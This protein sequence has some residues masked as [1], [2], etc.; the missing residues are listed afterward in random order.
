MKAFENVEETESADEK[1]TEMREEK[2][3]EEIWEL[4]EEGESICAR[5]AQLKTWK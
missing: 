4:Y 5:G 2:D 3:S 1:L